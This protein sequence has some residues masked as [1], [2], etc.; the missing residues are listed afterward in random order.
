MATSYTW[1]VSHYEGLTRTRQACCLQQ[2]CRTHQH[3][4]RCGAP[5]EG[6]EG[7][8][9]HIDGFY[10]PGGSLLAEG[11]NVFQESSREVTAAAC[12]GWL[13]AEFMT[14]YTV[15]HLQVLKDLLLSLRVTKNYNPKKFCSHTKQITSLLRLL[16]M[17]SQLL[18]VWHT[19]KS[20]P[21]Q[22]I[23][24][25]SHMN[26]EENIICLQRLTASTDLLKVNCSSPLDTNSSRHIVKV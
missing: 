23:S 26:L 10:C 25:C 14:Q 12:D 17:L 15:Y 6:G 19:C 2:R 9:A 3:T 20:S 1:P 18:C 22:P 16:P 11:K 24:I 8:F 13:S 5:R 7:V 4:R 21:L